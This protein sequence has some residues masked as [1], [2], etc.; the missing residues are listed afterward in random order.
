MKSSVLSN[1]NPIEFKQNNKEEE[2]QTKPSGSVP[3][4]GLC[5]DGALANSVQFFLDRRGSQK[6][7]KEVEDKLSLI[8]ESKE[9]FSDKSEDCYSALPA[10]PDV[11]FESLKY[12]IESGDFS[13]NLFT[14]RTNLE[15]LDPRLSDS[16]LLSRQW[17]SKKGLVETNLFSNLV[18]EMVPSLLSLLRCDAYLTDDPNIYSLVSPTSTVPY[19][20]DRPWNRQASAAYCRRVST[21]DEFLTLTTERQ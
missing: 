10:F 2:L 5:L 20:I 11:D 12:Q 21:V 3:V 1:L 7:W 19:L 8:S 15:G 18:P 9:T 13:L 16:G 4:I 14:G 6:S 17:L